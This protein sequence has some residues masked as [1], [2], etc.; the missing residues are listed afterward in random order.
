MTVGMGQSCMFRPH[1]SSASRCSNP[2]PKHLLILTGLTGGR[3][4]AVRIWDGGVVGPH[5]SLV[6]ALATTGRRSVLEAPTSDREAW[7]G[8][9]PP[10]SVLKDLEEYCEKPSLLSSPTM[11]Q[12]PSLEPEEALL[13]DVD[14]SELRKG[15]RRGDW[16][17]LT[18]LFAVITFLWGE[19]WGG[20]DCTDVEDEAPELPLLF[21]WEW[22]VAAGGGAPAEATTASWRLSLAA[23]A[24]ALAAL[25]SAELISCCCRFNT[26]SALRAATADF[27]SST[28]M[29][30]ASFVDLR[31][32]ESWVFVRGRSPERVGQAPG[33]A[34]TRIC[35][36]FATRAKSSWETPLLSVVKPVAELVTEKTGIHIRSASGLGNR[37][38]RSGGGS[39]RHHRGCK[40]GE[41][42]LKAKVVADNGSG[43]VVLCVPT[44]TSKLS[45][46]Q[47]NGVWPNLVRRVRI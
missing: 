37:G 21:L 18:R 6:H 45:L 10:P 17:T 20:V 1:P 33:G 15:D 36:S 19:S 44:S 42:G 16:S 5:A 11:G 32:A 8:E 46:H 12:S 14:P 9:T 38:Q 2:H 13:P 39:S 41:P 28:A 24:V 35:W 26:M 31:S 25:T 4:A 40:G 3:A 43:C 23:F 7:D 22:E 30:L 27:L 47:I 29:A 34:W